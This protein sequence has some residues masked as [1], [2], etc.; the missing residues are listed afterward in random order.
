[1]SRIKLNDGD[2]CPVCEVGKLFSKNGCTEF[3]HHITKRVFSIH[4]LLQ[5]CDNCCASFIVDEDNFERHA[6]WFNAMEN[7]RIKEEVGMADKIY[8]PDAAEWSRS[9]V[10]FWE[11]K[12]NS[13]MVERHNMV[14]TEI[15]NLRK[16]IAELE[17][18]L[19]L[20]K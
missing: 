20:V 13:T 3:E 15:D 8:A 7:L 5:E 16:R 19:K 9:Q 2:I 4:Q 14:A 11:R 12:G 17:A 6:N 18:E 10:V 1:V